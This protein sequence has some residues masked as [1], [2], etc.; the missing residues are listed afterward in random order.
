MA[1]LE[2]IVCQDCKVLCVTLSC[3]FM[4]SVIS[5]KATEDSTLEK[6]KVT[7]ALF[8]GKSGILTQPRF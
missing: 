1:P 4:F 3:L 2:I 6:K 5:L 7:W 8:E